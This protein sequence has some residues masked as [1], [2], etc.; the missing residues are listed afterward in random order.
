MKSNGD[1]FISKMILTKNY[2]QGTYTT[3]YYTI[4]YNVEKLFIGHNKNYS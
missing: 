4:L 2:G 1:Q 3:T